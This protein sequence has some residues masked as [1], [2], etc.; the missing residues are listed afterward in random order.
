MKYILK[1]LNW[2]GPVE[3]NKNLELTLFLAGFNNSV[4]EGELTRHYQRVLNV[5]P[6]GSD[7]A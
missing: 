4:T 5:E 2:K 7:S 6:G 3:Y 1:E